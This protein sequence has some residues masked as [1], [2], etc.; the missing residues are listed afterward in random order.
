MGVGNR[1][2]WVIAELCRRLQSA[3][4]YNVAKESQ[5]SLVPPGII[6]QIMANLHTVPIVPLAISSAKHYAN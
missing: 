2:A 6:G 3:Q 5:L 1:A 4:Y